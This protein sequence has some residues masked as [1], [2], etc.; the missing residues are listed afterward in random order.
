MQPIVEYEPTKLVVQ[1]NHLINGKFNFT[2]NELRIFLFLLLKI[3]KGDLE[4]KEIKIPCSFLHGG[5][6]KVNYH[7]IKDASERLTKKNI[8]V[9]LKEKDGKKKFKFIPLMAMCEYKEGSGYLVAKFNDYAKPYLLDLTE[10]FTA[11]QFKL[12]MNIKSFYSYRVY[13]LLKQYEDFGGKTFYVSELKE[14]LEVEDKYSRYYDFKRYVIKAAHK[15]LT[16]TDMAFEFKEVK[17]GRVTEKVKFI[18]TGRY[19]LPPASKKKKERVNPQQTIPFDVQHQPVSD[20]NIRMLIFMGFKKP[21]AEQIVHIIEDKDKLKRTL[22]KFETDCKDL[23]ELNDPAK[24]QEFL[25][26]F[27]LIAKTKEQNQ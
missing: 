13:W 3:K 20:K 4:F 12:F 23:S 17:K 22:Y 5:K 10:Y 14:M 1:S 7:H 24:R 2:T 9:E 15:E 27:Q 25:D 16:C 21:E 8:G 26:I 6:A 18:I 11:A 19:Q